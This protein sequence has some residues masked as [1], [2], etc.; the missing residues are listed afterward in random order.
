MSD[1]RTQK[2]NLFVKTIE[3]YGRNGIA[4]LSLRI[5]K[6]NIAL[7]TIREEEQTLVCYPKIKIKTDA[8][9][10]D[11]IK[12]GYK[13]SN[14]TFSTFA[15]LKKLIKEGK[16]FDYV[17]IDEVHKLSAN[18][19]EQIKLLRKEHVLGLTGTLKLR[20]EKSLQS[21]LGLNVIVQYDL[22][23]AIADKLVKD[24]K[25]YIHYAELDNKHKV[26]EYK[27][28]GNILWGSEREVYDWYTAQMNYFSNKLENPDISEQEVISSTL[29]IKK[30]M[31]LRTNFLYNVP[32]LLTKSKEIVEK[33]KDRKTL[34]FSL[35]TDVADELAE[36]SYHSKN[37]D[38]EAFEEFKIADGGHLS[39]VGMISEG[40]TITNLNT[41]ICHTITSN[42]EDFQQKLGR[43]LMLGDAD[44]C[45]VHII[46]LKDTQ[47][48]KWVEEACKSLEQTKIWYVIGESVISKIDFVKLQ[49]PDKELYLYQGGFCY[50]IGLNPA[51]YMEYRF[52]ND[53]VSRSY[54]LSPKKLIKL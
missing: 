31:G 22:K 28:F 13:F 41:I 37:V 39:T 23:D 14:I 36:S 26:H 10:R 30:Y 32:T 45:D 21:S 8:W 15:G 2:Q 4:R 44:V 33:F 27:K 11:I 18:N 54:T 16:K 6:T 46:C 3:A 47:Q 12:F 7:R 9:D 49:H 29:G 35:R 38:D 53:S 40:V 1:L 5:G 25:L 51:G 34:I 43:G 17:I 50:P 20:N 48:E 19:R 24:Y 42:T 52:L